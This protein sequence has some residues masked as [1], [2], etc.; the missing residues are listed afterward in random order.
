MDNN[1]R[2]KDAYQFIG[3]D[4]TYWL[5]LATEDIFIYTLKDR[6][7]QLCKSQLSLQHIQYSQCFE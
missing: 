6:E 1:A 4:D 2:Y 5:R 7:C 3:E